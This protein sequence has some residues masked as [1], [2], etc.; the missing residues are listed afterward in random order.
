MTY[1]IKQLAPGSYDV[2]LDGALVASLVREVDRSEAVRGWSV[3][4]LD[5]MSSADRP[6]PFG[7]QSHAFDTRA[8]A[9]EWL[10]IH[11]EGISDASPG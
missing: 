6:A 4:L 5:E 7:A 3:E 10:G 2:L 1:T 8:A 11:G 9:L